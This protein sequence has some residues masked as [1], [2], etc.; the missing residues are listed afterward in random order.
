MTARQGRAHQQLASLQGR[1]FP[2]TLCEAGSY[3]EE[4]GNCRECTN[5]VD[6]TSHLNN[7]LSCIPCTPCKSDEREISPCNRTV[8]RECQCKPGTFRRKDSPEVCETCS[9]RCSDGMVVAKPCTPWSNLKCVHQNSGTHASREALVPGEPAPTSPEPPTVPLHPQGAGDLVYRVAIGSCVLLVVS[10]MAFLCWKYILADC[11]VDPKCTDRSKQ[12]KHMVSSDL[13]ENAEFERQHLGGELEVQLTPQG[14]LERIDADGAG[15][16]AFY[17]STGYGTLEQEGGAGIK[18]SKD[19][20]IAIASKLRDVR[21]FNGQHFILEEVITGEFA[22]VKAWK[23][24]RVGNVIFRKS[25][26]NFNLPICKAAETTV[27][28][29]EEIVD[30]GSFAPEDIHIPKIYVHLL[31]KGEKYEKR[32]ERLSIRKEGGCKHQIQ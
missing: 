19:R 18:Y 6:Y 25:A 27:V 3:A 17:T 29:V 13:G 15:I 9:V 1:Q 31:I 7:L 12:V 32:I 23:A 10:L 16:P 21:E 22:L 4:N 14:T 2:Q 24:D 8:D 11:G 30:I 5:G 28:E 26:R 20:S